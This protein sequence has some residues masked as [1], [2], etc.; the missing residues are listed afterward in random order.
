MGNEDLTVTLHVLDERN[1]EETQ[2]LTIKHSLIYSYAK[3]NDLTDSSTQEG[4]LDK[5][6]NKFTITLGTGE[7]LYL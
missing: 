2:T 1:E 7:Y 5:D 3:V 6:I 4:F